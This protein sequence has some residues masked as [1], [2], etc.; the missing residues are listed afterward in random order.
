MTIDDILAMIVAII[1]FIVGN[2]FWYKSWK[3]GKEH[4]KLLYG[5]DEK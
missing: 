5:K 1:F 3:N 2:Y 4:E